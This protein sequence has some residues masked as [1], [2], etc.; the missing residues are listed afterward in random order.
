MVDA[1]CAAANAARRGGALSPP[2]RT[3]G[4]IAVRPR[5]RQWR[6][7]ICH[8]NVRCL[9]DIVL[10]VQVDVRFGSCSAHRGAIAPRC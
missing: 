2:W 8:R 3:L 4:G 10:V 5:C 9:L 7:R 1:P 6:L